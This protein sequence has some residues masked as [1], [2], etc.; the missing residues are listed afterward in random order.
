MPGI[1]ALCASYVFS[2]F[3]RAFLAVL[4]D[5]LN[6]DLGMSAVDLAYAS[7]AWF[8]AFAIFQFPVG[9]LLDTR[10]PRRTTGYIFTIFCGGGA[11]LFAV[12]Q[13]PLMIIIAMASIG[14]GCS[15][16]LMGP[17]YIFVREYDA[18]KFATLVSVFIGIGTLGNIG[19]SAPL[20]AAVEAFGWRNCSIFL[21]LVATIVGIAIL[22]LVRE[23]LEVE[24]EEGDQSGGFLDLLRIRELWFIY[25]MIFAGYAASA[26]LR[27]SWVGP[28]HSEVYGY[29]N[30]ETGN[31]VLVM[32]IALVLGTFAFGPLDRLFNSRKWVVFAGSAVV[33]VICT[34][35]SC[36]LPNDP[37]IFTGAI[38]AIGF[39]GAAYAVQMAHGKS[40]VPKRMVGRGVTL[41]NFCAIGGAGLLQWISGPIVSAFTVSNN[42]EPQYQALFGFYAAF[43]VL[44]LLVYAFSKDAKPNT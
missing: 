13:S 8:L 22:A 18:A 41:L 17:M 25:P 44:A 39:F 31:A 42:F 6:T 26:G 10:G 16:A 34:W 33:A 9:I 12:A 3:F 19:S 21:G 11:L 4:N 29:N 20:A 14:V 35:L 7:G 15:P 27:G 28:I 5:V 2:Q 43:T 36:G 38:A 30:L 23:P 37:V 32:A 24:A 1:I 40:F